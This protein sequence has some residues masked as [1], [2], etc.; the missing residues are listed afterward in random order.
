MKYNPYL[1]ITCQEGVVCPTPARD[2]GH[3]V[4]SVKT[5]RVIALDSSFCIGTSS[6]SLLFSAVPI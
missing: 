3:Q 4:I 6:Y 5:H 2:E 1:V